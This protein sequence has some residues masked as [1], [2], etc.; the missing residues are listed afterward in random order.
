[1]TGADGLELSDRWQPALKIKS[2]VEEI[3]QTL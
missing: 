1:M 3:W 2:R